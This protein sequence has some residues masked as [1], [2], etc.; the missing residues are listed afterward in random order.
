MTLL[1]PNRIKY[2]KSKITRHFTNQDLYELIGI[3]LIGFL[4]G[5]F[6]QKITKSSFKFM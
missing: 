4:L 5:I 3:T 2:R 6:F 1:Q